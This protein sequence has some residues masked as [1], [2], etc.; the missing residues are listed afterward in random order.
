MN[1]SKKV[2]D[3]FI[4]EKVPL[5]KRDSWP[6]VTDAV[7]NIIWIPGLKKP[8]LRNLM[9]Q[10]TIALYYNIDSMKSVGASKE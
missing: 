2:K 10:T 9:L 3:I 7:G 4:D 8:F 6:I 1:G 5:S